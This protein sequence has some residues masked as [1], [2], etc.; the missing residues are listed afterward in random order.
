VR[1]LHEDPP[2]RPLFANWYH[3][4]NDELLGSWFFFF[5]TF[6]FIPYS[7]VYLSEGSHKNLVYLLMLAMS[8]FASIGAYMFVLAC[9][10]SDVTV[11]QMWFGITFLF[12]NCAKK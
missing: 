10:P 2:M 11:S 1:A 8:I 6:M 3:F 12:S 9:Y 4:Q 5:A 7:M